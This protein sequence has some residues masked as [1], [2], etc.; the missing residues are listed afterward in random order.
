[1]IA[2]V[3]MSGLRSAPVRWVHVLLAMLGLAWSLYSLRTTPVGRVDPRPV[4]CIR[5]PAARARR[6][7]LGSREPRRS[8]WPRHRR[9]AR[10]AGDLAR[11]GKQSS[12]TGW[13][14]VSNAAI[15]NKGPERLGVGSYVP[16]T[17]H[18][19]L[20]LVM[21]GYGGCLHRRRAGA[22][23]RPRPLRARLGPRALRARRRC[24]AGRPGLAVGLRARARAGLGPTQ[25]T[26]T[27]SSGAAAT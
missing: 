18:P 21:H 8:S 3:L 19:E 10:T 20:D 24:C 15:G 25:R 14:A 5:N 4:A 9:R 7:P 13:T 1:M 6:G 23:L 26:T 12:R 27:S 11:A 22:Q 17:A 2:L 16:R